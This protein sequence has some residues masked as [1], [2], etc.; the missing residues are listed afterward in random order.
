MKI[1][2]SK[3]HLLTKL[4]TVGKIVKPSKSIESGSF[5]FE[6]TDKS[7]RVT[8]CDESGQISTEIDCESYEGEEGGVSFL[9]DAPTLLNSLKE[10]PDQPLTIDIKKEENGLHITI[11]YYNGKFGIVAGDPVLFPRM[12][13]SGESKKF[14]INSKVLKK[15]LLLSKFASTDDLRPIMTTV[16]L[17]QLDGVV[18]FAATS[19]AALGI[20]EEDEHKIDQEINV[21]I[22]G[23]ISKIVSDLLLADA[24]VDVEYDSRSIQFRVDSYNIR[25]RLFEGRYPNFRSVIPAS[26]ALQLRVNCNDLIAAINRVSIFADESSSMIKL[27]IVNNNL[28]LTSE[29][30]DY[31]RSAKED[32]F[33]D[34]VFD[35]FEIGFKSNLL[36]EVLKSIESEQCVINLSSPAKAA[37]IVPADRKDSQFILMPMQINN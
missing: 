18:A 32:L 35:N 2:V 20:Y 15:G 6:I 13:E 36:T 7:F 37:L 21:N 12:P 26:H 14:V 27:Q 25:Y 10:L 33:L 22:P 19:G 8:G 34:E 30:I 16:N 9:L 31:G 3:H 23:K 24:D 4:R 28:I 11:H 5:L 29:S 1:I 17:S